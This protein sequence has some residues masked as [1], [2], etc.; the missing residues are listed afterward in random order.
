MLRFEDFVER[1]HGAATATQL[2]AVFEQTMRDEGFENSFLG[3]VV[4]GRIQEAHWANLPEGH[5]ENYLAE[6]WQGIDPILAF[7]TRAWR[8]FLW[9]DQAERMRF[10]P[11]QTAFLQ[12]CKRVGVLWIII[13]PVHQPDGSCDIVGV[14]RRHGERPDPA[15][16][17]VMQAVCSQVWCRHSV[18]TGASVLSEPE[19][20]IALT[21]RELEILRW[22][23]DGKS[24]S[25]ISEIMSLSVKTI[26]YHV[27]NILRKLGA[28]NRT[29]AVVIALQKQ[30]LSL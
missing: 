9:D 15:Q 6:G 8:P 11:E 25:D 26:E 16:V 1:T 23:K 19:Q 21:Q 12:E 3:K 20:P 22:V 4:D 27:G 13:S 28:T 17:G 24:N 14:S 5:F 2:R 10:G 7:A 29:M 30:L 18:L